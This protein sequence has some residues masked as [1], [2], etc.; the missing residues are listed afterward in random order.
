MQIGAVLISRIPARS[1]SRSLL[2]VGS[3]F[4]ESYVAQGCAADKQLDNI[5]EAIK[6]MRVWNACTRT[7]VQLSMPVMR[8]SGD[9]Q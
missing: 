7:K 8:G 1:N 2:V 6:L 5:L 3:E 9:I 4:N